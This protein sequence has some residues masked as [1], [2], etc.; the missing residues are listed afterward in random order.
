M[1]W[2]FRFLTILTLAAAAPSAGSQVVDVARAG[3]FDLSVPR[4]V[5]A[6]RDAARERAARPLPAEVKKMPS[7]KLAV[8]PARDLKTYFSRREDFSAAERERFGWREVD[9]LCGKLLQCHDRERSGRLRFLLGETVEAVQNE[10]GSPV[11]A[12]VDITFAWGA[13]WRYAQHPIGRGRCPA[14]NIESGREAAQPEASSFWSPPERLSEK[15][16]YAGFGRKTRPDYA[17]RVWEYSKPKTSSG[18]HPGF[19]VRSQR[20]A[21]KVKFGEVHS[22]PFASRLLDAMGYHVTATD[23]AP[24]LRIRYDRRLFREFHQRQDLRT[25]LQLFGFLPV[26]TIRY[27]QRFDPFD[28]IAFAVLKDGRKISTKELRERLFP[29]AGREKHPEDDPENFDAAFERQVAYL[30]TVP[31][32]VEMRKDDG[33][34]LGRWSFGGLDHENRRELRGLGLLAAWLCWFDVRPAN[35]RLRTGPTGEDLVHWI[36]DS[37][38]TLGKSRGFMSVSYQKPADFGW[39]FTAPARGGR[40]RIV[41]YQPI[42]RVPAFQEMTREDAR[43]MARWIGRLSKKQITDALR[44]AGFDEANTRTYAAK[45]IARRDHMIRDLGLE[46]EIPLWNPSV[47]NPSVP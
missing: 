15:D 46:T 8:L 13:F 23:C 30:V 33:E 26:Y 40:V 9:A 11:P 4:E 38:G 44:G 45:L 47:K 27:Q 14:A 1:A 18:A 39:R 12:K 6:L 22:E 5:A 2:T 19:E 17:A 25:R 31:A 35:T 37:G 36:T 28:F 7:S 3:R 42:E 43:W 21:M 16:L 24:Q 32:N 10:R 41:A 20:K 29:G 34:A